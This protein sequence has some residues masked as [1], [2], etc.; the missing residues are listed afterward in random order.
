MQSYLK[1]MFFFF[2]ESSTRLLISHKH[3]CMFHHFAASR[4]RI[5]KKKKKKR[6][7]TV[8]TERLCLEA[9]KKKGFQNKCWLVIFSGSSFIELAASLHLLIVIFVFGMPPEREACSWLIKKHCQA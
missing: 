6:K 5:H 3:M 2:Q 9:E 8:K 4:H 7:K 1:T